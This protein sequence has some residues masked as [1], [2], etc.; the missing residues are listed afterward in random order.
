MI[1]EDAARAFVG[2]IT[3]GKPGNGP[4]SLDELPHRGR[5][6]QFHSLRLALT[7]G[8][9]RR[10]PDLDMYGAAPYTPIAFP[11]RTTSGRRPFELETRVD[12]H[13]VIRVKRP[14]SPNT[15]PGRT[16]RPRAKEPI[17]TVV[18]ICGLSHVRGDATSRGRACYTPAHGGGGHAGVA[19]DALETEGVIFVA[20]G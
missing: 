7:L 15:S 13:L 3:R 19:L 6:P 5:Y 1:R 12:M 2:E 17:R 16:P 8:L 9:S 20:T 11:M 4:R 14:H 18:F 10:S